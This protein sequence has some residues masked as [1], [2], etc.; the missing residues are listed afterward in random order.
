MERA[1]G[2]A[3]VLAIGT[4]NPPNEFLQSNYPD[5]YFN[6]TNSNHMT[7]LKVKFQR[8]CKYKPSFQLGPH[9]VMLLDF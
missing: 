3:S 4:A 6:I 5:F 1:Q 7:N 9:N 8:I 2:P